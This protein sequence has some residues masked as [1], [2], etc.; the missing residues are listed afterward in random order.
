MGEYIKHP[1]MRGPEGPEV[2]IG[3]CQGPEPKHW[4]TW[5]T[6]DLLIELKRVGFK[7]WY[8]TFQESDLLG[9]FISF[10]DELDTSV[11]FYRSYQDILREYPEYTSFFL[12]DRQLELI[13]KESM[14]K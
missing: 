9:E 2:K 12:E 14:V 8:G 10:Y 6:K 7:D 3:V 1:T 11:I 5:F 4:K 13:K